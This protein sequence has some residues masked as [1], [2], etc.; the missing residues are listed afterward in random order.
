VRF[1][2]VDLLSD[3]MGS[4]G[5]FDTVTALHVLEHFR[6][7]DMYA[8][9]AKLLRVTARRLIIAVPYEVG[10]PEPAYGHE[11]LFMREKLEAVGRWCIQ[12]WGAG[13]AYYEECAGGLIYL[14]R[15]S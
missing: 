4:C 11:Q 2:Q 3:E 9:L 5:P 12:Q 8:V 13:Q 10:T 14:D 15:V 1:D 6:E 7:E